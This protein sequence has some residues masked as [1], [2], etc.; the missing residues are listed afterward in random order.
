MRQKLV[1]SGAVDLMIDIRGNFFYTRT[2]PCQLWFF[3]RAKER[4]EARCDHVLMLDARNIYR[5]VTRAIFDFS[6][7]QQKNIAAIVWLYRGQSERFLSLVENYLAQAVVEGQA[8]TGQ[9]LAFEA[10]LGKLTELVEP[11]ATEAR[12]PDPM[13]ETWEELAST[14]AMLTAD[15]AA[16]AA[17]VVARCADWEQSRNGTKRDNASLH[18][19]REGLHDMAER[20]RDL[21]KQI[22]QAVKL[23]NRTVNI[24][25]RELDARESDHWATTDINTAGRA[26]EVARAA[27]VEA[28]RR[29]R[30]FVLQAD[31]LQDCFP[32]AELRD[33]EGLVKLVSR[34]EIEAHDWSLTPGRYVGVAPEDEAEDFDFEEALRSIHID[35]EGLNEEAAELGTRISRNFKELGQ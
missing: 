15:I 20:C 4:D 21:T 12:D 35:L 33:V 8:T 18:A 1:E 17:E 16:L 32:K 5:K 23:A 2:V 24:A 28:L 30:Y 22:D 6:P 19:A 25:V 29:A 3:D 10:A 27:G 13:A 11:F 9:L 34:T 14:Q 7:E 31:W 26:L